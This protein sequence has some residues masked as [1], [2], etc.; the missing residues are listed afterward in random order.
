MDPF[1]RATRLQL[2]KR[3]GISWIIEKLRH[4]KPARESSLPHGSL[5]H[6][7]QCQTLA[8]ESNN[9][10]TT[11]VQEFIALGFERI[12]CFQTHSFLGGPQELVVLYYPAAHFYGMIFRPNAG[13]VAFEL[14]CQTDEPQGISVSN[15]ADHVT[16]H[17]PP[18]GAAFKKA[19]ASL[20]ELFQELLERAAGKDRVPA[21]AE[22]FIEDFE[23]WVAA[24]AE[25]QIARDSKKTGDSSFKQ[26]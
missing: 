12:G 25:R 23:Y 20:R 11:L 1:C 10:V 8:W 22:T 13:R 6:A 2:L 24:T 3:M 21:S 9:E 5:A 14:C 7:K 17:Q 4:R 15:D 18:Y 26:P 16:W 19:G